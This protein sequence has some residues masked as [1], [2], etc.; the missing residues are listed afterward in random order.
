MGH[1]FTIANRQVNRLLIL[2]VQGVERNEKGNVK[3]FLDQR[4]A[5]ILHSTP[6][7]VAAGTI[8]TLELTGPDA[9][10]FRTQWQAMYSEPAQTHRAAG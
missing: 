6:G 5:A 1:F 2:G 9:T 3:L 7:L 4:V 8:E 10:A